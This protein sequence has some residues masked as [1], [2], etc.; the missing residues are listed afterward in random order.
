MVLFH[1]I[2]SY[3][4]FDLVFYVLVTF[5][6]LCSLWFCV[7]VASL[8]VFVFVLVFGV[9][10]FACNSWT[11]SVIFTVCFFVM[12]VCLLVCVLVHLGPQAHFIL[13]LGLRPLLALYQALG[14]S[15]FCLGPQ[16][17]LVQHIVYLHSLLCLC[18]SYVVVFILFLY[19]VITCFFGVSCES[20]VFICSFS[21]V[22]YVWLCFVFLHVCMNLVCLF[23]QILCN[24][25]F[26]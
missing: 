21:Y 9:F 11:W 15:S 17:H 20:C 2:F 18:A 12:C 24:F 14:P 13:H 4:L 26:V 23:L 3:S 25:M 5:V 1:V 19:F 7:F 8:E 22:S 6:I 16:A 10:M